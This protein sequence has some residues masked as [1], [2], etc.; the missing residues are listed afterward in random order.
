MRMAALFFFLFLFFFFFA[1]VFTLMVVSFLLA[2]EFQ[3][4]RSFYNGGPP[5]ARARVSRF[6]YKKEAVLFFEDRPRSDGT[7]VTRPRPGP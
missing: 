3:R 4:Y 2:R 1:G 7:D 6:S 5:K